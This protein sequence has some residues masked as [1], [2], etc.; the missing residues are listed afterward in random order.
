MS[1]IRVT[2]SGLISFGVTIMSLFTGLAF[3]LIVTR[4]LSIDDFGLWSLISSILIYV[5]IF[6]P[7]QSF[8]MTR[9]V[10]R[11]EE[12]VITGI[13]STGLFSIAAM[14]IYLGI[15]LLV[16][17]NTD[18]DFDVLLL[19]TLM[20][21]V[22][23]FSNIL[24]SSVVGYRPE[25]VS[26]GLLVFEFVKIPVGLVLVYWSDM[27]IN[28]AI[29]TTVLASLSQMSFYL[30]Y[31]RSK[32][33]EK[34]HKKLFKNWLKLSWLPMLSNAHDRILH[35]DAIIFAFFTG[36]VTAI[37]YV[38]VARTISNLVSNTSTIS[39]GL[40]PKLLSSE[41]K[42]FVKFS[43]RQTM[44]F[45]IPMLGFSIIF[46]KAGLWILNPQYVDGIFIVYLW[47]IIH[48]TYVFEIILSSALIGMEKVD[49][50]FNSKFRDY[51]KSKLVT[52]PVIYAIGYTIYIGM[53]VGVFA[54]SS[55][56]DSTDL[57]IIFWW[58]IAGIIVN[59][60]IVLT[61]W[62]VTSNSIQ[63]KFP[64]KSCVKN[65]VATLCS[66]IVTYF[67]MDNFL[68]YEKSIFT[69]LPNLIPFMIIFIII[70]LGIMVYWDRDSK[71]LIKAIINEIKPEKNNGDK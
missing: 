49:I 22:I 11:N 63:F 60:A 67:L 65:T 34:F 32:L 36:S 48:F 70:Y 16:A 71:N 56:T 17:G 64:V 3:T 27:G 29:I 33:K 53:L 52:I 18:A 8:W 15:I 6:I 21:P 55:Q 31:L 19:A 43:F 37:A 13:G 42:E 57:E 46:A 9:H 7:I 39:A 41:K 62:K 12:A 30:F 69:F 1:N 50:N 4:S 25:A 61:F 40:Y 2:Y 45:S 26:Y 10:A 5:M 28:G 58:G 47:S 68:I 38:G 24:G 20:I 14:I 54:T 44:L 51:V 23:Y 59:T 35:L 66:S